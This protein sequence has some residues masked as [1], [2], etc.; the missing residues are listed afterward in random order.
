MYGALVTMQAE[1]LVTHAHKKWECVK[2]FQTASLFLLNEAQLRRRHH[3][4][5][6]VKLISLQHGKQKR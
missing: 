4:T 3:P 2:S 1:R 6:I 5:L